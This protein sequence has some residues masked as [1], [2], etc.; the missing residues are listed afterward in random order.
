MMNNFF[1]FQQ[2]IYISTIVITLHSNLTKSL[3]LGGTTEMEIHNIFG[4]EI[5][6]REFTLVSAESIGIVSIIQSIAI[7]IRWHRFN[8][9]TTV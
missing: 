1:F 4:P 9:S 2:L 5:T 6:P 7:A 8:L 3:T